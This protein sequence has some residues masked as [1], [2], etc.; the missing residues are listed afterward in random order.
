MLRRKQTERKSLGWSL[1]FH[2]HETTRSEK[3][4]GI[5]FKVPHEL[6]R[7]HSFPLP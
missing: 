1:I 6:P 3:A 4:E 7:N 5:V 2:F